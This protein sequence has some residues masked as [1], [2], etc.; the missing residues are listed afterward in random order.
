MPNPDFL[1]LSDSLVAGE[2]QKATLT[3]P[4]AICNHEVS[5]GLQSVN[6]GM[7]PVGATN[8]PMGGESG[9]RVNYVVRLKWGNVPELALDT[10]ASGTTAVKRLVPGAN[11]ADLVVSIKATPSDAPLVAGNFQDILI[12]KVGPSL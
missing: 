7:R 2:A 1:S 6:G 8:K 5:I 10:A 4:R 9:T 12:V 3:F 11:I